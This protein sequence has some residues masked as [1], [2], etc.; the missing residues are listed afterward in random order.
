MKIKLI[1]FFRGLGKCLF[2]S[3]LTKVFPLK[4]AADFSIKIPTF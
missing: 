1:F 3:S 2:S 4:I